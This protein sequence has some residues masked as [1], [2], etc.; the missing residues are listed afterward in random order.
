MNDPAGPALSIR[1]V[2]FSYARDAPRALDGIDLAVNAGEV[3]GIAGPNGSGKTTLARLVI[4]LLRP[5][6]GSIVVDGLDTGRHSM[7]VLASHVGYAFQDPGHQLF[8]RT[9]ADELAFGPR[10]LGLSDAEVDRRVADAAARLGIGPVL[11]RHP[12]HLGPGERRIVSIASVITMRPSVLILDEPTTGQDHRTAASLARLIGEL[13]A[14][15][16]TVLCIAHDMPLLADVADRLVVLADGRVVADG[17]TRE[18]F[19]DAGMMTAAGLLA[20]QVTRLSQRLPRAG[21][22]W[23]ALSVGELAT[24]LQARGQGRGS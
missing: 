19:G 24:V 4:G 5:T 9:V 3:V 11:G 17:P 20:P 13:R 21:G 22:P 2:S 16:T 23:P 6:T 8:A 12:R 7:R 18:V 14:G 10:N 1:G 15:G